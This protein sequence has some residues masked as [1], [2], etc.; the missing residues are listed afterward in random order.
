MNISKRW[1]WHIS[2]RRSS[3]KR[4]AVGIE[5]RI[6]ETRA[7]CAAAVNGFPVTRISQGGLAGRTG[8]M[9][10]AGIPAKVRRLGKECAETDERTSK[11]L[12]A[13]WHLYYLRAV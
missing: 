12:Q 4:Y 6:Q 5:I 11:I 10:C 2:S 8:N 13:S 9:G 7:M 3:Q 1:N